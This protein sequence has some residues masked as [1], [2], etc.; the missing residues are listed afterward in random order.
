MGD[1]LK[2][3]IERLLL[4]ASAFDDVLADRKSAFKKLNGNNQATPC[5]NLV[6]LR[7]VVSEFALLKRA[8]FA[9]IRPQFE[10]DLHSSRNWRVSKRIGRS[11]F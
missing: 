6:N 1:V 4:F 3:R 11:Q 5:P 2:R 10:D 9:V 8:I 7:P